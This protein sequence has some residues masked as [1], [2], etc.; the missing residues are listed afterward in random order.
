VKRQPFTGQ[1]FRFTTK[2]D[3]L[4]AIALAWPDDDKLIV[5][6]L[7]LGGTGE[8]SGG[9]VTDV[10][11]LGHDGRLDWEQ[12]DEGLVVTLPAKPASDFAVTLAIRG[13]N[14]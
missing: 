6:S 13:V 4:Y 8:G 10:R 9:R 3:T 7:A 2:G 12:T 5:K 11:L 14:K 1:D